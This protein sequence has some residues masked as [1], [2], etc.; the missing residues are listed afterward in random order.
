M[1]A[2]LIVIIKLSETVAV[3][4]P[5]EALWVCAG[6]IKKSDRIL[7]TVKKRSAGPI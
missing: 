6:V 7:E 5:Q 2:K 4:M 1:N 3:H